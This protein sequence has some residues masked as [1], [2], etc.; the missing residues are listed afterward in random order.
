M[1][2]IEFT[3]AIAQVLFVFL[4][5]VV[6]GIVVG[7]SIRLRRNSKLLSSVRQEN[8]K[9]RNEV[10]NITGWTANGR[11]PENWQEKLRSETAGADGPADRVR[12]DAPREPLLAAAHKALAACEPP[13]FASR[14]GAEEVS[15]A[16]ARIIDLVEG[17]ATGRIDPLPALANGDLDKLF[18]FWRRLETYF[19]DHPESDAYGVA[20]HALMDLLRRNQ[21]NVFAPRPLSVESAKNCVFTTEDSE[22]LRDIPRVRTAAFAVNTRFSAPQRGEELVID[23]E[24]PGWSGPNGHKNARILILDRSW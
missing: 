15:R 24:R 7:L 9:L 13:H 3:S 19:P 6:V 14:E 23:C 16:H 5:I 20:G 1:F 11:L 18:C 22:R 10:A 21:V 8:G 4:L 12:P 2:G 17:L